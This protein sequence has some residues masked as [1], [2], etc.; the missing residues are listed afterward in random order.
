M[1]SDTASPEGNILFVHYNPASTGSAVDR[2]ITLVDHL[3]KRHQ[4]QFFLPGEGVM[5]RRLNERK[6]PILQ[7]SL[8][9]N[10]NPFA[11]V[12]HFLR[13][14]WF[15]LR[16]RVKLILFTDFVWWKPAEILA[17]KLFGI[18]MVTV[19]GFYRREAAERGFLR[20]VDVIIPNSHSTAQDFLDVGLGEKTKVIHNFLDLEAYENAK[21]IRSELSPGEGPLI[22]YVGVLH[23]VK[24]IEHLLQA[25]PEILSQHPSARLVL[26][27]QEKE[28]GWQA[29][30]ES[31]VSKLGI[32]EQV[33]FLGHRDDIPNVMKSLDIL[34]VPSLEEPFG[35]INIE[36]GAVG[37]A[38]VASRTGGI[39]EIISNQESGLL[40]EPGNSNAI[41]EAVQ[42]LLNDT[43]KRRRLGGA[44]QARVHSYFT[45]ERALQ[46]WDEV[47]SR[48]LR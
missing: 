23:P 13:F 8:H 9:E 29:H 45:K 15:L 19:I 36:A 33:K 21:D 14:C 11:Y 4:I 1:P 17:A 42:E 3:A 35:F 12:F 2:T 27:G 25:V 32:S 26:V 37:T 43:E 34:V 18:P 39:P 20:W 28:Q 22:G 16:N 41:S 6:V 31:L 40:I 44:L 7:R 30:L 48:F 46:E 38:V 47:F 5:S 24:G 10:D